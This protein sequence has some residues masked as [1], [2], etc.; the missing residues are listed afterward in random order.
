MVQIYYQHQLIK[1]HVITDHYRH[2]DYQDFPE[3]I[4]AVLDENKVLKQ[5]KIQA[6]RIGH[7]FQQLIDQTLKP[8]AFINMRRAQGIMNLAENQDKLLMEQAAEFTINQK[9]TPTPKNFQQVIQFIQQ[10]KQ[11]QLS[12]P[13]SFQT[14]EFLRSG[15]YFDHPT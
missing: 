12:L 4:Q 10:E 1:Q 7:H 2:T 11:T 14:Q 13:L 15:S 6:E 5:L 3:N 9:I 8:H